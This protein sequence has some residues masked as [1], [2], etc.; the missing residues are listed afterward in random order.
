MRINSMVKARALWLKTHP[1]PAGLANS[2][3]GATEPAA[4][5]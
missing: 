5:T 3:F 4:P 2:P 1:L